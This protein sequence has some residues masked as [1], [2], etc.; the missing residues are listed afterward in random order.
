MKGKFVGKCKPTRH[1]TFDQELQDD[2]DSDDEDNNIDDADDEDGQIPDVVVADDILL[3]LCFLFITVFPLISFPI[4]GLNK[5]TSEDLS[6]NQEIL[7]HM[8]SN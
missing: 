7:D 2:S 8:K 5:T 1:M 3:G 4:S 6:S